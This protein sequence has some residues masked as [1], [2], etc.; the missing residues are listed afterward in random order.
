[1]RNEY[2]IQLYS[3]R[4]LA[5]ESLASALEA[6]SELGYKYVEFAGFFGNSAEQVLRMLKENKLE[7]SG[8]HT[9]WKE[10]A[11]ENLPALIEFHKAIRN[12][13]VII[14][15]FDAKEDTLEKIISYV[16]CAAPILANHGISIGYHNH[17]FEFI[18]TP[19]GKIIFDE[20]ASKTNV[21]LEIDVF[22]AYNAGLDPIALAEK[23]KGRIKAFH[24]KDGFSESESDSGKPE[25]KALG[26]G[27]TPI[28]AVIEY[29]E[30]NGILLIVESEG[31]DPSGR[32]E[33][34]RCMAYLRDNG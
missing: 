12:K 18:R 20:I 34:A 1:M 22:W 16:N 32:E 6:V 9:S 29:A 19:Y 21:D 10:L 13:N 23:Y 14:P 3:I 31:L 11:P 30:K 25:G 17:S 15:A 7:V 8:T 27:N 28:K 33:V 26:E 2:G 4:D 24:L 5:E